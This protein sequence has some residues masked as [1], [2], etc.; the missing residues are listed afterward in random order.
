M[1]LVIKI[2]I[3]VVGGGIFGITTAVSLAKNHSVDLYEQYDDILKAAS[4]INQFRMHCGY[5][6][7]RSIDT[8]LSLIRAQSS[9]KEEYGEALIDDVDNY[10]CIAKKGSLTSREE[11]IE[12]CEKHNLE[13]TISELDL[14][15]KEK[16]DICIKG[17]ESLLD[18][19]KL[20]EIC[21]KRLK[22]NN[23]NVLLNKKA[24]MDRLGGYDY[25]II[26][27]YSN[28]NAL[29]ENYKFLQKDY[30]FELCEKLVLK[31]P[32]RFN[33]KSI[34]IMDGPFFCVDPYGRT[35][36]FLM[37]NVV[38]AI[39]QTNIGKFPVID[40]KFLPLLNKGII[41]N[42]PITNFKL[43]MESAVEFIP[44]I[45]KAQHIGSMFTVRT[46]LPN[47]DYSDARPTIVEK[48]DNRVITTF[49]GKIPTCVDVANEVMRLINK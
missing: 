21:W 13:F 42:P 26:A 4:G 12:F 5:H 32:D 19:V 20:K 44:E 41:K 34:V 8:T 7:P 17:V 48:I 23:V 33:K 36:L 35:G 31:L 40:K 39:H 27:A 30:Q 18:P 25:V 47:M 2:K 15:K 37:G 6:Y 1:A 45:M 3:A 38:H 49:S 10:Y 16:I 29:L 28:M 9:F 46:V 14:V 43:F 24:S 22:E 11:Y